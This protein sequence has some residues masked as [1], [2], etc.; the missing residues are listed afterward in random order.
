MLSFVIPEDPIMPNPNG[1]FSPPESPREP[2]PFDN[3]DLGDPPME[4]P[5]PLEPPVEE[6]PPG[7]GASGF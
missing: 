3:P 4:E 6:P 1:P 7:W 2:L 5:N